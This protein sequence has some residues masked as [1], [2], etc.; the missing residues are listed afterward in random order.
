[1]NMVTEGCDNLF[2]LSAYNTAKPY[3]GT[4]SYQTEDASLFFGRDQDAELVLARVLS[5]RFTLLH[6][7]SG[8]GKT[9]LLNARLIPI[10]ETKGWLPVRIL[11]QN[12][13]VESI[14]VT[15]VQAV[16]PPLEA[17]I[18]AV[19]RAHE[20]LNGGREAVTLGELLETYDELKL[21]TALKR[22]H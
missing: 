21:D 8:A 18:A 9:S 4:S 10:L 22:D 17:E 14:C 3:K 15:C 13:P 12:D 1:M 20:S 19:R 2:G 6:A 16:L 7:Q 5:S 11:P